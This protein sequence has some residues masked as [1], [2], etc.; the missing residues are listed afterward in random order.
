MFGRVRS[1][2]ERTNNC[3]LLILVRRK[4][5]RTLQFSFALFPFHSG[6]VILMPLSYDWTASISHVSGFVL[7]AHMMGEGL[8]K[9]DGG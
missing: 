6:Y 5:L 4:A 3:T 8:A 1:D 2:F 7:R 9:G